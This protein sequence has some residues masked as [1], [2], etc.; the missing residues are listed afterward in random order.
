MRDFL[1]GMLPFSTQIESFS[2]DLEISK[3][4]AA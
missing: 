4:M 2:L 3:K 1:W